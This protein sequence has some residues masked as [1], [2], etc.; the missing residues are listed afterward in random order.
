VR[1]AGK[2]LGWL[3]APH[4]FSLSLLSRCSGAVEEEDACGAPA[5]PLGLRLVSDLIGS[6]LGTGARDTEIDKQETAPAPDLFAAGGN[7]VYV[8][9][10]LGAVSCGLLLHSQFVN[11]LAKGPPRRPRPTM[12][13]A[14]RR[15]A[16]VNVPVGVEVAIE[17]PGGL[18]I[19]ELE[20][21]E[22][23]HVLVLDQKLAVEWDVRLNG[24]GR[25]GSC[26]P[27]RQGGGVAIKLSDAPSGQ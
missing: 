12:K 20:D 5:L 14:R 9:L 4:E 18:A 6:L 23:G 11:G 27:G 15:D 3:Q 2:P 10:A 13:L 19:E 17:L 1:A 22:V 21:F 7:G 16:I 24:G 8:S 26:R 25:I